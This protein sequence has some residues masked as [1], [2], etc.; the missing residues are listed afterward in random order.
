M[1]SP[2]WFFNFI[3]VNLSK[4]KQGF[5]NKYHRYDWLYC[6]DIG[7]KPNYIHLFFINFQRKQRNTFY[8]FVL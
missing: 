1:V 7:L 3:V 5:V 2:F 8:L 4:K 6:F